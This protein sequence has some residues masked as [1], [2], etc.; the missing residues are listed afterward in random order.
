MTVDDLIL[1]IGDAL[2]AAGYPK[3]PVVA[4]GT[5]IAVMPCVVLAPG[6]NELGDGNRSLRYGFDIT[7]VVPRSSQPEQYELLTELEAVVLRSL[8]PSP[9]RFDGPIA[10]AATGGNETGEP[11]ALSRV[12]PVTFAADVDLC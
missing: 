4:P 3:V 9:V 2:V 10:F 1:V 5:P 6:D 11:P 8:I 7:I 12:I